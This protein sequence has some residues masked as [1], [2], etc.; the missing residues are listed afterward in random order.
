[1]IPTF[2]LEI[3]IPTWA[4]GV[5][6]SDSGAFKISNTSGVPGTSDWFTITTAGAASFVDSLTVPGLTKI[7][8]RAAWGSYGRLMVG[9]DANTARPQAGFSQHSNNSRR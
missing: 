1:M 4:V 9:D 2:R 8:P 7:N 5:D 6:R 3:T